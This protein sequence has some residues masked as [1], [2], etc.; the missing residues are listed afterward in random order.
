MRSSIQ[1]GCKSSMPTLSSLTLPWK[2]LI[3][4]FML[5][6]SSGFVVSELYL[7]H[8]TEMADG[9][10]GMSLDDITLTF[11]GSKVKTRLRSEALGSMKKYFSSEEEAE[12]LT[13]DEQ[14]DLQRL[15]A[16]NDAGAPEAEFF[17]NKED[18][19]KRGS[20]F[21]V[22]DKHC[23][24]CH[25]PAGKKK[26]APLN[27]FKAV[28]RF[29]KPDPGMD[30]GRLLMLSHVHLLGMGM[31]FLLAGAAVAMSSFPVWM[32][33]ALIVGGL[34]SILLDIFGWWGV[35]WYGANFSIVVMIGGIMMAGAFG[36]S[37][38]VALFDL[39]I[40]KR[41]AIPAII[42]PVS[43]QPHQTRAP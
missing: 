37:V 18:P 9:K 43:P 20:I 28:T 39:W 15:I 17:G 7:L 22:L 38:F 26:D 19:L 40:R 24:D 4:L 32:R 12:K 10:A 6:L 11:Y 36:A 30:P 27:T 34:S 42:A 25:G 21:E 16:W 8:T 14:A 35:K 2:L 41:P 33:C 23:I 29:T 5:V 1:K 3:T 13:A 31:M